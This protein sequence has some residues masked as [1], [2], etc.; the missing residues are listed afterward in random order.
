MRDK[1]CSSDLLSTIMTSSSRKAPMFT[2][3]LIGDDKGANDNDDNDDDG[4]EQHRHSDVA[5]GCN[6]GSNR[7]RRSNN[8]G[9]RRHQPRQRAKQW[10]QWSCDD[11]ALWLREQLGWSA[12]IVA[13]FR[14]EQI[15]GEVL[16]TLTLND[17]QELGVTQV[18]ACC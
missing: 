11:V 3:N 6:V 4:N 10:Q 16:P 12:D 7:N 17:L 14:S 5:G 1:K 13:Q 2:V 9:K 18:I 15:N 8:V